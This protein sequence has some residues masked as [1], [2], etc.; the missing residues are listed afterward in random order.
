M[1]DLQVEPWKARRIAAATIALPRNAAAYVDRQVAPCADRIGPTALDR[2]ITHAAD[3]H[4]LDHDQLPPQTTPRRDVILDPNPAD[5]T[6]TVEMHAWLDPID[7]HDLNHTL[8]QTAAA[9]KTLGSTDDLPTRRAHALG[10]L[11][12]QDLTLTYNTD[13]DGDHGEAT[14]T[15]ETTTS[16]DTA[17]AAVVRLPRRR[18]QAM[19]Y[20]HINHDTLT[21]TDTAAGGGY[22][23]IEQGNRRVTATAVR[24]WLTTPDTHITIRPVL[25]LTEHIH[26][27]NWEAGTRA[28]ELIALRDQTCR[29]PYCTRPARPH[30]PDQHPCDADHTTPYH[31][32]GPTCTCQL[33]PLCRTHHR[34][35]TFTPWRYQTLG[36]PG[37]YLWTSPHGYQHTVTPT[38]TTDHSLDTQWQHR[39]H[40]TLTPTPDH[41]PDWHL[42]EPP[43]NPWPLDP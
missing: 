20:I 34:A 15:S 28:H 13:D 35:K 12:R 38:G 33:V 31:H 21:N 41:P 42:T 26:T 22:A 18:R 2:L 17:A 37:H 30:H 7:A 16:T 1:Q 36:P 11:A 25:D 8:S 10:E 29:F 5:T 27:T 43:D 4:A 23:R 39:S 3:Q 6:G 32:G 9:L 14:T 19:L 40:T 24:D